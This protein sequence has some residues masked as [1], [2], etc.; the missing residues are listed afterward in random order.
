MKAVFLSC[1]RLMIVVAVSWF[2][3]FSL[4]AAWLCTVEGQVDLRRQELVE[5]IGLLQ[6]EYMDLV[7]QNPGVEPINPTYIKIRSELAK[8]LKEFEHLK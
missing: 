7:S 6:Q 4:N 2:V 8:K 3:M 1:V 5:E